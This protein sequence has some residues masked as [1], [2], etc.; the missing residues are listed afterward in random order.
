[1]TTL[2]AATANIKREHI[3]NL[4]FHAGAVPNRY[5]CGGPYNQPPFNHGLQTRPL[6]GAMNPPPLPLPPVDHR[7]PSHPLGVTLETPP[8]ID[9]D[10]V[11]DIL[12]SIGQQM[13]TMAPAQDSTK[14]V[15]NDATLNVRGN[16]SCSVEHGYMSHAGIVK[17][18]G[19]SG[20]HLV[21]NGGANWNG[22]NDGACGVMASAAKNCQ[23]LNYYQNYYNFCPSDN[24][25]QVFT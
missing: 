18:E 22:Y 17:T 8:A 15:S 14:H 20:S 6:V 11:N 4:D 3:S 5:P 16:E 1:M 25:Q 19:A 23:P 7:P 12:A 13:G 9:V 2:L 21:N 24:Y 10:E